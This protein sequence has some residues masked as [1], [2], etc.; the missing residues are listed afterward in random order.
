LLVLGANLAVD[1][2]LRIASLVPGQ[3][4]RPREAVATPG[5]KAVN[6][7]RAAAAHGVRVVLVANLPGRTGELIADLLAGEGHD[8][9][10]V[11]TSGEA[12]AAIIF[13]EDNGRTTVINEPGPTL[14]HHDTVRLMVT[15]RNEL[16]TGRHRVVVA[17]GSLPP[18]APP[19]LYRQVAELAHAAG[20]TCIVDAARDAL[21]GSLPGRPDVVS[22]NLAEA[23]L[24]LVGSDGEEV[25]HEGP[26]VRSR[27]AAAAKGLVGAGACAAIVSAGRH[28]AAGYDSAGGFWVDAPVVEVRNPIG[29][30]DSLVAGLGL[31]LERGE[32]FREATRLG[33]A[34]ASASVAHDLAGGVE[35]ALLAE[36]L[37]SVRVDA[38]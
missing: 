25:E 16:A 33:I 22:P 30:G 23:E 4:L 7:A 10:P 21:A 31:A 1:R 13:L 38:A 14:I 3:V 32:P 34:T 27:A 35:P 17:T 11:A 24:L 20:S 29:A 5:G 37:G 18:G 8:V 28:G 12:R 2:T 36:L 15:V 19:D 9:R 26:D 6:V